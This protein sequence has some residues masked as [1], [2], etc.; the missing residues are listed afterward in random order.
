MPQEDEIVQKCTFV[1]PNN[2]SHQRLKNQ[3]T[4]DMPHIEK[5]KKKK[6]ETQQKN[7]KKKKKEK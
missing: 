2:S 7:K 6:R 5:K 1:S 4:P 3:R